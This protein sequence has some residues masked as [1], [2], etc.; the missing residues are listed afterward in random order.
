MPVSQSVLDSGR[1]GEV[2]QAVLGQLAG[3][4]A[5]DVAALPERAEARVH[6]IRVGMKKFRAIV[7]LGSAVLP[8]GEQAKLDNLA[9]EIK[10]AFGAARDR[11]V[12][13][14]LLRRLLGPRESLAAA[15]ALPAAGDAAPPVGKAATKPCKKLSVRTAKLDFRELTRRQI[16]GSW[17]TSYQEARRAMDACGD[18]KEDDLLFHEWRKRVKQFLYQSAVLGPPSDRMA[19]AAQELSS[20]LGTQ[21]DLAVLCETISCCGPDVERLAC[22]EKRKTA[23][24]AL[25]LGARLFKKKPRALMESL[26]GSLPLDFHE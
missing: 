12:Q 10:G 24:L 3:S 26:S 17:I 5:R 8:P 16:L 11:D 6:A 15:A 13:V 19:P 25:Q 4:V 7:R 20:V 23:R 1:P 22:E 14:A 21:H 2:V 18:N 9:C